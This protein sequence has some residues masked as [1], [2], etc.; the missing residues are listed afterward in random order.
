MTMNKDIRDFIE[1]S[2]SN[3][4]INSIIE[5]GVI[6]ARS[7]DDGARKKFETF[8]YD[9]FYLVNEYVESASDRELISSNVINNEKELIMRSSSKIEI[10]KLS[11]SNYLINSDEQTLI[12]EVIDGEVEVLTSASRVEPGTMY[13]LTEYLNKNGVVVLTNYS[14]DEKR[15]FEYL[16]NYKTGKRISSGFDTIDEIN[17]NLRVTYGFATGNLDLEGNFIM[18]PVRESIRPQSLFDRWFNKGKC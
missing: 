9:G 12:I 8:Q 10:I 5:S 11:D 13:K 3:V 4:D 2:D 1:N 14:K 18:D 7:K 15:N 17:G 16:Y 6:K